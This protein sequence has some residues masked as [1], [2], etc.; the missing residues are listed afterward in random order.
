MNEPGSSFILMLR[1]RLVVALLTLTC[2]AT[3][4]FL[5][6]RL[7]PGDPAETMLARAGA[8]P[9]AVAALRAEL[10]LNRPLLTQYVDWLGG[11]LRGNLGRSLLN[12]RPV[13]E[14]ISEQWRS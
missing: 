4:V 6:V 5:L 8:G 1:R 7:L 11:T 13:A 9:Q 14:L 3:V 10:G 2:V 12:D